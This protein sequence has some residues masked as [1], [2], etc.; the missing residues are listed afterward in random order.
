MS[1]AGTITFAPGQ[2]SRTILISTNDDLDL[3]GDETFVINLSNAVGGVIADPQAVGTIVDNEVPPQI[4]VSA[5]S[6]SN[7]YGSVSGSYLATQAAD[8]VVETLTEE[9]Y[10]WNRRTRLEHRWQSSIT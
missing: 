5:V 10:S 4:D 2:T 7:V 8:G 1:A 9:R 6:E 3:E